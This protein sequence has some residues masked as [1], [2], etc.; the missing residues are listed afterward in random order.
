MFWAGLAYGRFF[1]AQLGN[2]N[3]GQNPKDS[4]VAIEEWLTMNG[5]C[6]AFEKRIATLLVTSQ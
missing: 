2:P 3:S 4:S 6:I 1:T 5:Y